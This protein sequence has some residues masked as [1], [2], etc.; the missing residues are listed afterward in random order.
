MLEIMEYSKLEIVVA[1]V[2]GDENKLKRY[3]NNDVEVRIVTKKDSNADI[4]PQVLEEQ[5]TL[6][7]CM[8][9]Y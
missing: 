2:G 6:V 9:F 8:M 4:L 1:L 3:Y 7:S 5:G